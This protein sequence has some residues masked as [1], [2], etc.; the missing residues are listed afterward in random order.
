[1]K[2]AAPITALTAIV[3]VPIFIR[4]ALNVIKKR[5]VHRVAVGSGEHADLETAIRTHGNFSEYVPFALL[6]MLCAELNGSP[7]WLVALVA[8]MLVVGRLIHASAI[9]AGNLPNRVR[10]MK[11][12]FAS[13]A[14]GALANMV[15]LVMQI[16]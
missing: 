12:T 16:V 13:L 4:L 6:L 9:P 2:L 10:S 5:H 11:L 1:M 8:I 14:L 15:P 7:A 3:L